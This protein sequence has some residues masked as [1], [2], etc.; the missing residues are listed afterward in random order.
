MDTAVKDT[1]DVAAGKQAQQHAAMQVRQQGDMA[2]S[3]PAGKIE[4]MALV[5]MAIERDMDPERLSALMD[6][7]ERNQ[8]NQARQEF[9]LA[10][11]N[12]K[13]EA[14][15]LVKNKHVSFKNRNNGIT[16]Y[17][18]ATL[19]HILTQVC[20][21]MSKYGLSHQ[22][23][24]R[25]E[26]GGIYVKCRLSHVLGHFEEVEMYGPPDDSGGKNRIQQIGSTTSYLQRY[27]FLAITGL[28]TEE[29]PDEDDGRGAGDAPEQEQEPQ[30][31]AQRPTQKKPYPDERFKQKFDTFRQAVLAG[32][33]TAQE[34]IDTIES[35]AQMSEQQKQ[36]LLNIGKGA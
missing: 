31:Q 26:N 8:A 21:V 23:F 6:L 9:A 27:T 34:I 22:W 17:N 13:A 29:N 1:P 24:T 36:A 16:Q 28:A 2:L 11:A 35:S 30:Q 33:K 19:D 18:H 32:K 12:F 25:Q 5:Q 20:P 14:P 10:M 15:R 3:Q 4:P 7:A